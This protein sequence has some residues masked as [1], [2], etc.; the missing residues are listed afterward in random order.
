VK[1][2]ASGVWLNRDQILSFP[3]IFALLL[4]VVVDHAHQELR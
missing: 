4:E 3:L 2:H 1:G